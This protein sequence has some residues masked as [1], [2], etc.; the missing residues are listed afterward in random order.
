MKKKEYLN[1]NSITE[2]NKENQYPF[3]EEK[4]DIQQYI[5][6]TEN[7]NINYKFSS[8][9]EKRE[10]LELMVNKNNNMFINNNKDKYEFNKKKYDTKID[11]D[12]D[13]S[14]YKLNEAINK[15]NIKL[16][17]SLFNNHIESIKINRKNQNS[18]KYETE[19]NSAISYIHKNM[20]SLRKNPKSIDNSSINRKIAIFT[21]RNRPELNIMPNNNTEINQNINLN[22]YNSIKPNKKRIFSSLKLKTKSTSPKLIN[23]TSSDKYCKSY[24]NKIKKRYNSVKPV[25][26]QNESLKVNKKVNTTH[27]SDITN[28]S[29]LKKSFSFKKNKNLKNLKNNSFISCNI[30]NKNFVSPKE[31]LIEEKIKE[32]NQETLKFREERNKVNE[33]KLEYEKLQKK[34]F[35]DIDDFLKKKEEFEKFKQN[36]INNI[37]KERKNMLIDNKWIINIKNQNKSLELEIKKNEETISQLKMQINDLQLII[38]NKDNEIKNLQKIINDKNIYKKVTS[39]NKIKDIKPRNENNNPLSTINKK[40]NSVKIFNNS[41][42]TNKNISNSKTLKSNKPNIINNN[43]QN[44]QSISNNHSVI[45]TFNIYKRIKNNKENNDNNSKLTLNNSNQIN[46]STLIYN[47][48]L[49]KN[50]NIDNHSSFNINIKSDLDYNSSINSKYNNNSNSN[51]SKIETIKSI[52]NS[53]LTHNKNNL[54]KNYQNKNI[55]NPIHCKLKKN[56]K[57]S[58]RIKNDFINKKINR[59]NYKTNTSYSKSDIDMM[60]NNDNISII[61]HLKDSIINEYGTNNDSE[62][63]SQNIQNMNYDFVIPEKY[64]QIDKN[65]NKIVNLLNINGNNI[66]IYTN[67]KKEITYPD[68]KRQIIYNDNHQII[69]YKNGNIKQIFNNGKTV[70]YDCKEEKVETSYENGI[71]IVKYKNGKLERFYKDNKENLSNNI[72]DNFNINEVEK[73]YKNVG[74]FVY[75][76][77]FKTIQK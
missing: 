3:F 62:T 43:N 6:K 47:P 9:K 35:N 49:T 45:N 28:N 66:T 58:M 74:T 50:S 51:N 42:K 69:Y 27:I 18:I 1:L 63:N 56:M 36:E 26:P 39:L 11:N 77:K 41:E 72:S 53:F 70:F 52:K 7:P 23:F 44:N 67:N 20:V 2:N 14:I 12:N 29:K 40:N 68:G 64:I 34:L 54:I 59:K 76:N 4:Q 30:K 21:D 16:E 25:S 73:N 8:K 38:K 65:N 61:P 5:S 46:K 17:S 57:N 31:Q 32:L 24:K 19:N 15:I 37:N 71:K 22:I 13:L 60:M 33:L 55:T 75:N 10:S 48:S